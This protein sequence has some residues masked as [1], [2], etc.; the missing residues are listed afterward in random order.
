MV[1]WKR[2][3]EGIRRETVLWISALAAV[4]SLWI[5]PP[6]GAYLHYIDWDVLMLLFSLMAVSAGFSSDGLWDRL[7]TKIIRRAG[8]TRALA[9]FLTLLSFFCAMLVT[10][11]VALLTFVPLCL[12]LLLPAGAAVI[13]PTVILMTIAA[14]LGSMATPI[15]NPQNIFLYSAYRL[16]I[17]P[18]LRTIAPTVGVS[19]LLIGLGCLFVPDRPIHQ[20]QR[21]TAHCAPK[22]LAFHGV[23]FALCLAS[24]LKLLPVWAVFALVLL[25]CMVWDREALRRVDYSLLLTFVFFFLLA[26]NLSSSAAIR[27]Y[28]EKI[29]P[30]RELWVGAGLSQVLSNVPAA[31][32]L[33]PFTDQYAPLLLGV[34][35]GGLGTPI[36][37]LASLISYRLY[38]RSEDAQ[39]G[40]YMLLFLLANLLFCGA[41]LLFA[42]YIVHA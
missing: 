29:L 20:E 37:S 9:A 2:I 41:L 35:I 21:G 16:S 39:P 11:D 17:G 31:V 40:R 25:S 38:V 15:G 42:Q 28:L 27:G 24:V 32:L 23:L 26:G 22:R 30:G 18:F 4:L 5:T 8:S 13:M 7:S 3:C 12:T 1:L 6:T 34:N 10:N 19:L 36:A 33:A 14:N